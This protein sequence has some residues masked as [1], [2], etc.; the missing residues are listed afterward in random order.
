MLFTKE[1]CV[2][3]SGHDPDTSD[4]E[5]CG[6][7]VDKN[8]PHLVSLGRV[9]EGSTIVHNTLNTFFVWPTHLV[10][11]FLEHG[12]PKPVDMPNPDVEPLYMMALTIPQLFLKLLQMLWDATMFEVYNDHFALHIKH[13]DLSKIAHSVQCLGISLTD[14][15]KFMHYLLY[16]NNNRHMTETKMDAE[17]IERCLPMGLLELQMVVICPKDNVV[18]WFCSLHNRPDNYLKEIINK[19][20]GFNDSQGSKSKVAARWILVKQKGSIEYEYYVMHWMSTIVLGEFKDNWEM[21]FTDPRP[22]EPKRMKT[23]HI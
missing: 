3:P 4:L 11:P 21:Y 1:S 19:S 23:I 8:P 13:E 10:Q 7:Y 15:F 18:I 16:F 6:L 12:L 2:D 20:I 5:K 22:L 17:F 9:Y 14:C